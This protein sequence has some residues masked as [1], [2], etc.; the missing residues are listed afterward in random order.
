MVTEIDSLTA[1]KSIDYDITPLLQ[2]V[3]SRVLR[4]QKKRP[5]LKGIT[6]I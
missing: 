6:T 2:L 5:D 1:I 3:Q 4:I